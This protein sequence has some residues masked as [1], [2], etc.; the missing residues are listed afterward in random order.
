MRD[1]MVVCRDEHLV[2][3]LWAQVSNILFPHTPGF[4]V[5]GPLALRPAILRVE[6]LKA[7]AYE[8]AGGGPPL[9]ARAHLGRMPEAEIDEELRGLLKIPK[10]ILPIVALRLLRTLI[11]RHCIRILSDD[12]VADDFITA[13]AHVFST[14]IRSQDPSSPQLSAS[15]TRRDMS[16]WDAFDGASDAL[17]KEFTQV[18]D[19]IHVLVGELHMERMQKSIQENLDTAIPREQ[20]ER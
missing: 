5:D 10:D 17:L 7:K 20:R 1:H 14:R 13:F 4:T 12:S 18:H 16:F 11:D 9:A 2:D 3:Q 19:G 15:Y 6:W 8:A